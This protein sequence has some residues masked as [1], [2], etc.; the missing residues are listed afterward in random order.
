MSVDW[1][2]VTASLLGAITGGGVAGYLAL[3]GVYKTQEKELQK[4]ER[5][6]R[7]LLKALYQ[8]IHDEVESLWDAYQKGF[9]QDLEALGDGNALDVYYPP[10]QES[11]T[12]FTGNAVL[13]GQVPDHDLRRLVVT[14]YTKA[15]GIID[16]YRVNN[17]LVSQR[18]HWYW[19]FEQTGNDVHRRIAEEKHTAAIE[20]AKTLKKLHTELKASVSELLPTLHALR[21]SVERP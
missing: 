13:I 8:A 11:L 1:G 6:K 16:A 4:Q 5:A 14:T 9:G 21:G 19:T 12:I 2:T 10:N 15:R 20:H 7:E 3:R 17:D 18:D